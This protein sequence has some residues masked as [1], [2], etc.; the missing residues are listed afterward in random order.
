MT[1]PVRVSLFLAC[2]LSAFSAQAQDPVVVGPDIYKQVFD[3]PRVR[4]MEVTF[5]PGA[6][7]PTHSHPDH[8]G[9]VLAGGTLHITG[10]DGKAEA[11]DVK[12]GDVL[13]IPATTHSAENKGPTPLKVLVV[14]LKE[15]APPVK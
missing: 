11:R 6:K 15:P 10:A 5:A 2:A 3:N 9:Y 14:E 13:W 4:V 8:F 12:T 7:M 1:Q